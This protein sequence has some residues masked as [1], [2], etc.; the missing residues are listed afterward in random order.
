MICRGGGSGS[1]TVARPAGR[2]AVRAVLPGL[3]LVGL[4][5]PGAVLPGLVLLGLVLLGVLEADLLG[6]LRPALLGTDLFG[7][8]LFGADRFEAAFFGPVLFGPALF[9]PALF[10]PALFGLLSRDLLTLLRGAL[11]RAWVLVV[12]VPPPVRL[13]PLP[14]RPLPPLGGALPDP[15]L[16]ERV[17]VLAE[18]APVV[19]DRAPRVGCPVAPV[20]FPPRLPEPWADE[21][22]R[23]ADGRRAFTP[24]SSPTTP[25]NPTTCRWS[26][27]RRPMSSRPRVRR[28][29]PRVGPTHRG[30]APMLVACPSWWPAHGGGPSREATGAT[31]SAQVSAQADRS[32][33]TPAAQHPPGT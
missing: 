33:T 29:D 6:V 19:D 17:P 10:G 15:R 13:R 27:A 3:V 22:A 32:S 2:V 11:V 21:G 23:G 5:L 26:V 9:G 7:A 1:T 24:T 28:S 16:F 14:L 31:G 30:C 8:V 4:V 18:F 12:R 25:L 20:A